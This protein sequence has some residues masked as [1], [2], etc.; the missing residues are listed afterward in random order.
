VEFLTTIL[1]SAEPINSVSD[2]N[3]LKVAGAGPNLRWI[4]PAGATGGVTGSLGG[5]YQLY[6]RLGGVVDALLV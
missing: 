5:F 6:L 4:E 2:I 3:G 1:C